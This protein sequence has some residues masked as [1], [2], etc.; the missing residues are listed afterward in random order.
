MKKLVLLFGLA[1]AVL[2]PL[3]PSTPLSSSEREE[4]TQIV[5]ELETLTTE[6]EQIIEALKKRNEELENSSKSQEQKLDELTTLSEDKQTIIT[7]QRKTIDEQKS[8]LEKPKTSWQIILNSIIA[9]V[10]AFFGGFT[11]GVILFRS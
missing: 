4:L 1:F 2:L 11:T 3:C 7:E 8:L 6:Q 9:V 5:S 10:A